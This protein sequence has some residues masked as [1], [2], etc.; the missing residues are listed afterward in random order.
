MTKKNQL[1]KKHLNLYLYFVFCLEKINYTVALCFLLCT[2]YV[3]VA[4]DPK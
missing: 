4:A 3:E 1:I 2:N